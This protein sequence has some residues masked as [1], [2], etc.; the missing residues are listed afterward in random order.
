MSVRLR[1]LAKSSLIALG[2][3]PNASATSRELIGR[4]CSCNQWATRK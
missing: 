1:I 3:T 2:E 4:C